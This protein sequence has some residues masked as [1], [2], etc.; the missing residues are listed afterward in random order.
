MNEMPT[1]PE[2]K[3]ILCQTSLIGLMH[4]LIVGLTFALALPLVWAR[5]SGACGSVSPATSSSRQNSPEQLR[6]RIK[7]DPKDVEAL[8]SLGVYLEEQGQLYEAYGLYKQATESKPACYLGYYFLGL[9]EDRISGRAK[10]DAETD[11]RKALNLNSDL[12]KDGNV[13]AFFTRRAALNVQSHK[14]EEPAPN[15]KSLLAAGN[16]FFI[17][18]GVG[19]L[20]AIPF[21]YFLRRKRPEHPVR[22]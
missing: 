22:A 16:H 5:T 3:S 14:I 2:V 15:G 13:E 4:S 18:V 1:T 21:I 10:T 9:V 11:I 20:L 19:V 17:G 7:A 6:R 8:T 12:S